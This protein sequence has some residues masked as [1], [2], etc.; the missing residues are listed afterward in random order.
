MPEAAAATCAARPPKILRCQTCHQ[1]VADRDDPCPTCETK[2]LAQARADRRAEFYDVDGNLL[3]VR[4]RQE[5][6]HSPWR[7]FVEFKPK[8]KIERVGMQ[9]DFRD[10]DRDIAVQRFCEIVCQAMDAEWKP[11]VAPWDAKL[12]NPRQIVDAVLNGTDA[13][14]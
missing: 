13:K 12:V 5:Q 4:L 14:V 1:P 10:E 11:V 9:A 3:T 2:R 8:K 7:V 6:P